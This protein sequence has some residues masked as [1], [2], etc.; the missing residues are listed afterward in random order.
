MKSQNVKKETCVGNVGLSSEPEGREY[1]ETVEKWVQT[2]RMRSDHECPWL[3]GDWSLSK[4]PG[5]HYIYF[6]TIFSPVKN[7]TN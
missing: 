4:R 7:E 3:A 1:G 2:G 6:T 5:R